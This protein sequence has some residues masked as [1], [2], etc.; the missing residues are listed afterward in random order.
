MLSQI[1]VGKS[2]ADAQLIFRR[3]TQSLRT[4]RNSVNVA[5]NLCQK[6]TKAELFG[7]ERTRW[8]QMVRSVL[9]H[10]AYQQKCTDAVVFIAI[11]CIC[12]LLL[13]FSALFRKSRSL[14]TQSLYLV[15]DQYNDGLQM[16]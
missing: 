12:A 10:I 4:R 1:D 5:A 6:L 15:K 14:N 13:S 11:Y 8:G 2:C 7:N 16:Q 3:T 9:E